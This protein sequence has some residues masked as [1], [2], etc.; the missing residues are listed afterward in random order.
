MV[1]DNDA[2]GILA[3][4]L[5]VLVS[6]HADSVDTAAYIRDCLSAGSTFPKDYPAVIYDMHARNFEEL[7]SYIIGELEETPLT[8]RAV[9]D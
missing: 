7:I 1:N 2:A 6:W 3:D 8:V 4:V 9:G 5:A